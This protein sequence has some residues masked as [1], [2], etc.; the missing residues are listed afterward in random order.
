MQVRLFFFIALTVSCV[1]ADFS[2][3]G[4]NSSPYKYL[5]NN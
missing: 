2:T 5:R 1:T 3:L 4:Y